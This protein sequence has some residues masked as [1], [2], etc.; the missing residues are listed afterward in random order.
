MPA[1]PVPLYFTPPYGGRSMWRSLLRL[2]KTRN[3]IFG[4]LSPKTLFACGQTDSVA[5]AAVAA[6]FRDAYDI[7]SHL[8]RFFG[9]SSGVRS[10]QAA[11]GTL[12]SGSNALQFF[13][14]EVYPGADLDL[15][16]HPGHT[17]Q[18]G[19]WLIRREGYTFQPRGCRQNAPFSALNTGSWTPWK[20]HFD[21]TP[22]TYEEDRV[23]E[24]DAT[25]VDAVYEFLKLVGSH[26]PPLKV[27]VHQG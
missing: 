27:R 1:D 7:D 14:R 26:R 13:S 18:V 9:D 2:P 23:D 5:H 15:Y 3:A 25:G 10:L 8:Q 6:F 19:L 16:T 24:Y 11:T 17:H 21:N 20:T 12:I 4:C 22:F